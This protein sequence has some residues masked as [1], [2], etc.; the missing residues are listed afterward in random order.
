MSVNL[1]YSTK[2]DGE[3][4]VFIHGSS[5]SMN[6]WK[7]QV[8]EFSKSYRCILFDLRG[9]GRSEK[10]KQGYDMEDYVKDVYQ[11][12]SDLSVEKAH[13]IG[14][15]LGGIIAM[16]FALKYPGIVRS[17]VIFGTV[18]EVDT[19]G[20]DRLRLPIIRLLCKIIGR[21][22][23]MMFQAKRMFPNDEDKQK[24]ICE[25]EKNVSSECFFETLKSAAKVN[26]T[27]ELKNVKC[28][29]LVL[30]GEKEMFKEIYTQILLENLPNCQY[31][32]LEK[33][34]HMMHHDDPELFNKIVLDFLKNQAMKYEKQL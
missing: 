24:Q 3:A 4:I 31:I 27:R 9:H 16:L 8:E 22:K 6:T 34:G 28:P 11:L 25:D 23:M 15:S 19:K 32:Y 10:P 33:V 17:I 18:S 21:E 30:R 29:V 2:G 12:L 7:K 26:Y 20:L 5:S 13:F 1:N 14:N